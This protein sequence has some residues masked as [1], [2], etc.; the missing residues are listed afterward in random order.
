MAALDPTQFEPFYKLFP[1][2][3]PTETRVAIMHSAGMPPKE[4]GRLKGATGSTQRNQIAN[5]RE[6]LGLHT[7]GEL[8]AVVQ[9]R[10]L[11]AKMGG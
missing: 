6:K 1:E 7:S 10:L 3:T 8:R 11:L 9:I 2:L 5:A 4:I